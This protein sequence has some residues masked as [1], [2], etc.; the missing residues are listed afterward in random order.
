MGFSLFYKGFYLNPLKVWDGPERA[1]GSLC[2]L[3]K[4]FEKRKAI[5]DR[6]MG[7]EVSGYFGG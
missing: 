2:D 7:R 3:E 5:L 4:V 1:G 6:R